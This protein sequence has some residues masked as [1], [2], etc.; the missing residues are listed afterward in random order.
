MILLNT[1][2]LSELTRRMPDP[3]V[4][5]RLAARLTADLFVSAITEAEL[6]YGIAVLPPGKRQSLLAAATEDMLADDF[7]GRILLFDNPA[8]VAY[9]DIVAHRRRAGRPISQS[10]AQI[11]A[12]ARLR[13][14]A[15]AT[16]NVRDFDGC[17]ITPVNP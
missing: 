13:G 4:E 9:A 3:A 6:R 8:A 15:L 16:R 10:D 14:A 7:T 5:H 12:I 17:G 1:D 2:V 11:A